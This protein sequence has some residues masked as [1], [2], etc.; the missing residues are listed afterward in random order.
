[1]LKCEKARVEK[2]K[3]KNNSMEKAGPFY[4]RFENK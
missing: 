1:M 3:K 2:L 4:L